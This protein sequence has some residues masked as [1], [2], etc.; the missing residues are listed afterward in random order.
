MKINQQKI[1]L[2][3]FGL[4]LLNFL[5]FI[6][7]MRQGNIIHQ[8]GPAGF[9]EFFFKKIIQLSAIIIMIA[10]PV[11][12]GDGLLSNKFKINGLSWFMMI[13]LGIWACLWLVAA[14][15]DDSGYCQHNTFKLLFAGCLPH[16]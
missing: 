7:I 9:F 1:L 8:D 5:F 12:L 3:Y 11:Q 16:H 14:C 2:H 13:W 10:L 15:D 6:I 4:I